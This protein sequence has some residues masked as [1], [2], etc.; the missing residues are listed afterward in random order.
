MREL[1]LEDIDEITG[2]RASMKCLSHMTAHWE[3]GVFGRFIGETLKS[4]SRLLRTGCGPRRFP[5]KTITMC[6][7]AN[8]PL[9]ILRCMTTFDRGAA[10]L[11]SQGPM[12]RGI[13]RNPMPACSIL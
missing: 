5:S 3:K 2:P 13:R 4:A 6:T 7:L 8:R 9:D 11:A 10:G 1:G 12:N